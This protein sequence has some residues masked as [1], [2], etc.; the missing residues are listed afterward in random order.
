MQQPIKMMEEIHVSLKDIV[1]GYDNI[2]KYNLSCP[3][4]K[5]LLVF[6][7]KCKGCGKHFCTLCIAECYNSMG[8]CVSSCK[9][10]LL[11]SPDQ[12]IIDG[13]KT[14]LVSCK[15]CEKVVN[16]LDFF[17]HCSKIHEKKC[18]NCGSLNDENTNQKVSLKS[19]YNSNKF[20]DEQ[21]PLYDMV[22]SKDVF[23]IFCVTS[24][25]KGFI[26]M[27]KSGWFKRILYRP[28]A[29]IF[30]LYFNNGKKYLKVYEKNL[31]KWLFIGAYYERGVGYYIGLLESGEIEYDPENKILTSESGIT[32]GF[33]LCLKITNFYF[34][35]NKG[36]EIYEKCK[37]Q[38]IFI[39]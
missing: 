36:S 32:K 34:F 33:P 16:G 12:Q 19:F 38:F 27:D 13:L 31:D 28:D 3:L 24:R 35:F 22:G 2:F 25:Y 15:I 11:T 26:G 7:K 23:Q 30:Q 5:G 18:F 17:E 1:Q 14:V 20:K 9:I 39:N 8:S 21:L 29:S 6:P 37:V 4:C 10:G